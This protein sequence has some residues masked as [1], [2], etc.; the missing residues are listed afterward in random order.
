V[1]DLAVGV[2]VG[3]T[4]VA[5][6]LVTR[7]GAIVQTSRRPTTHTVTTPPGQATAVDILAAVT[8]LI[9][10]RTDVPIGIGLP[11]MMT[12]RGV[13][14]YAPNLPTANGGDFAALL[15]ALRPGLVVSCANDADC[16]ALAEHRLGAARGVDNFVMV[17]L[18]TGIGG[19][20][21]LDGK[22]VRGTNGFAGEIGHMV[23]DPQGPLCPCG[24][25]GCWERF[26]SGAGIARLA[27]EAAAAGRLPALV[28]LRGGDAQSVRGEDVT[29]AAAEGSEE[30]LAVIDE[31]AWW[32]AR[33]VANLTAILDVGLVVLGGGLGDAADLLIPPA[34]RA[35]HGMLEG[36]DARPALRFERA[37]FAVEA[38]A[39]G[40]AQLAFDAVQ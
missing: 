39:L 18:G 40:A 24:A 22:L 36:G 7:E 1:S 31:V 21:V 6:A 12:R 8:E 28:A 5:A 38:G 15:N 11:G 23:L 37:Q 10:E 29:T 3:G 33:G 13:L 34:R 17:T 30:A 26:A 25:R 2:D 35:L 4:K 19:G 9:G 14:A 27:R 32:L 16:A 20:V